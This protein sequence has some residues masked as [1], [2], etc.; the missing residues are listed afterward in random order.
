VTIARSI[1]R[2]IA[3]PIASRTPIIGGGGGGSAPSPPVNS[4][5]PVISSTS[6][7]V[8]S[9]ATGDWTGTDPKT[10]AYQWK[11]GATDVGTDSNTYTLVAADAGQSMTCLVAATNSAGSG[12]PATS[13]AIV[14]P[15]NIMAASEAFDSASWTKVSSVVTAND[16]TAPDGT[17]TAERLVFNDAAGAGAAQVLQERSG[18]TESGTYTSS[19]YIKSAGHNTCNFVLVSRTTG[20]GFISFMSR[21]INFSAGTFD[22]GSNGTFT[23]I[24]ATI[25]PLSDGWY[26]VAI[27]CT[28]QATAT[29]LQ[30][31][32]SNGPIGN[33]VDGVFLWGAQMVQAA[34]PGIYVPT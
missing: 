34:T 6:P 13:N 15:T 14:L 28:I 20:T 23:N 22:G 26:R 30:P 17:S 3:G 1:A 31:S 21:V 4:V 9:A 11:R 32:I 10:Y 8:L 24:T 18:L 2:P 5:A 25:E 12:S 7:K 27:A 19:F 33:G 16:T 29:R